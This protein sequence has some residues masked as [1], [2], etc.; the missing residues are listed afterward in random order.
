L[1]EKENSKEM[2]KSCVSLCK[3]PEN[4]AEN[5]KLIDQDLINAT[6]VDH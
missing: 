6:N 2:F 5:K 4:Y 3:L 1:K